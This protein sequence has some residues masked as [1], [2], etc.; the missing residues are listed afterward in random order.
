MIY[1]LMFY[2]VYLF[3]TG[4]SY[5]SSFFFIITGIIIINL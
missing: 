1:Y 5:T 3:Y 2:Q 4:R